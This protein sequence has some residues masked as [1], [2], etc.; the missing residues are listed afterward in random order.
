MTKTV[1][2]PGP[3]HPISIEPN[4]SRITVTIGGRV[5]A[6]TRE[7]LTLREASYPP[8][9]YIPR[10]DVDMSLLQRTEHTTYCPYKGECS[11]YSIPLGGERSANAVWTYED[12]YPAV[13]EIK[14]H[15]AFY[16]DRVDAFEVHAA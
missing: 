12:T 14:D 8:V 9:H 6:D 10:K 4:A 1:K 3:D 11:Y 5:L 7:A 16:T 15:L 2:T 13:A